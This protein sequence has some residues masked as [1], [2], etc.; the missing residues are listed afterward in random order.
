MSIE[1]IVYFPVG[2]VLLAWW[3]L[4]DSIDELELAWAIDHYMCSY[5]DEYACRWHLFRGINRA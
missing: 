3:N 2:L 1:H 4:R 5:G